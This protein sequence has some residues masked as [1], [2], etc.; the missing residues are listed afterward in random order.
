[1]AKKTSVKHLQIDKNQSTMLGIIVGAVVITV[2]SLFATKALVSKGLYQR[3]ALHERRL[4]V[5]QLKKNYDAATALFNQY[6]I[7]AQQDP[8]ILGGA[9]DGNGSK[10]GDNARIVLDALPSSYDAP[11]LATS[12]EKVLV[13][14]AVSID[15]ISVTDDPTTNSDIAQANPQAKPITF[16]FGG[17]STYQNSKLLLQDFEHSI[18]PFDVNTLEISGSDTNLKMTIGMTTYFQPAKSLD[19]KPTKE[20]K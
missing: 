20:V 10:N 13:G 9:I 12:L 14:R 15:T 3:R 16:S 17:T 11:A 2:F 1:M 8:N 19:L 7:F 4:V 5:D 18:R 6:K